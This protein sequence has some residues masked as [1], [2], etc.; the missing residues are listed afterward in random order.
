MNKLPGLLLSASMLLA[1]CASAPPPVQSMQ[2]SQ[3][4]FSAF[5]T[6]AWRNTEDTTYI[7]DN[8]IRSAIASELKAK[9]YAEAGP[10]QTPDLVLHY[11]TAAAEKAKSNPVRIGIGM[12]GA[13]PN[14]AM[15]MG[16]SSPS[17]KIVR[18][19]TLVLSVV[20]PHRNAEV[21]NGRVSREIASGGRPSPA[22]IQSA[23]AELLKGF[24]VRGQ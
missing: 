6:F 13:G 1:G 24:P 9:G 17:Q 22:L 14:G 21:W 3:A 8:D 23:V 7:L 5:N 4:N 10:G 16:V 12:G 19:G 18:E 11:E 2:D 20:D 15:G